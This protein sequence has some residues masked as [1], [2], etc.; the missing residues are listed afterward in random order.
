MKFSRFFRFKNREGACCDFDF[1]LEVVAKV[2][3]IVHGWRC[4]VDPRRATRAVMGRRKGADGH[5]T[6]DRDSLRG[7]VPTKNDN[8][9]LSF[10]WLREQGAQV[11]VLKMRLTFVSQALVE[12]H[13]KMD[14]AERTASIATPLPKSFRQHPQTLGSLYPHIRLQPQCC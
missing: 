3:D 8:T 11:V 7:I 6:D 5:M 14:I 13:A 2:D 1:E 9:R 4:R 12:A 10:S